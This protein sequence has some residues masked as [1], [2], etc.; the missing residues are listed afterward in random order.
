MKVATFVNFIILCQC[1]QH[2]F[3]SQTDEFTF[4]IEG[5]HVEIASHQRQSRSNVLI[6]IELD[7]NTGL[8]KLLKLQK[9]LIGWE[10]YPAFSN[11]SVPNIGAQYYSLTEQ[12]VTNLVELLRIYDKVMTFAS[13]S[14]DRETNLPCNFIYNP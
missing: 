2:A 14:N 5:E 7:Q 12:A 9:L 11:A 6:K 1:I 4:L 10:S 3:A 13:P 8:E